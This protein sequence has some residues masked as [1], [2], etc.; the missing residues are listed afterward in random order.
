MVSPPSIA[1]R[2]E[3]QSLRQL[4]G[5]RPASL[6]DGAGPE[7]TRGRRSDQ[8]A[9]EPPS[10]PEMSWRGWGDPAQAAPLPESLL[11]L[12]RETLG[13]GDPRSASEAIGDGELAA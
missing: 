13:V 6:Y 8:M 1:T 3:R 9:D 12:L 5:L 10:D 7:P 2:P 11:E 4:P